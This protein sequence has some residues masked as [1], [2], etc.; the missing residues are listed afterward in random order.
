MF[1]F[2]IKF[3]KEIFL[4]RDADCE[5]E[6]NIFENY[7]YTFSKLDGVGQIEPLNLGDV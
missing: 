1:G 6:V 2:L 4:T 5:S 3:L 7:F